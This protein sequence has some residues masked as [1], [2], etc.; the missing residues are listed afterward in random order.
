MQQSCEDTPTNKHTTIP[1]NL[2]YKHSSIL[3]VHD[4]HYLLLIP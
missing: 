2:T 4:L 3:H 1:F